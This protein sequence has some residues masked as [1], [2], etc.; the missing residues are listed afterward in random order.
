MSETAKFYLPYNETVRPPIAKGTTIPILGREPSRPHEMIGRLAFATN[1]GWD[2]IRASIEYNARKQGADFAVLRNTQANRR[3]GWAQTPPS[4]DWIPVPG[5]IVT[6]KKGR[7][8]SYGVQWVPIFRPGYFYPA[9]V[10]TTSFLAEFGVFK[11]KKMG[12][13]STSP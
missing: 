13:A 1:L 4:T 8:V 7:V 5:P 2:F 10:T 3:W 12:T 6:D 9:E 11:S